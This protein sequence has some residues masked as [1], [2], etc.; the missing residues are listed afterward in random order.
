MVHHVILVWNSS[1]LHRRLYCNRYGV[2]TN[3]CYVVQ[4]RNSRL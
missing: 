1:P 4:F 2:C 3:L